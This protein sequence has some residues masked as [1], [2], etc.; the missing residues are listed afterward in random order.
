M[1]W[2]CRLLWVYSKV[3]F[4]IL[5][6]KIHKHDISLH[7][8]VSSLISFICILKFS[9]YRSF[10]SLGRFIPKYF[11]LF[12]VMVSGIVSLISLSDVSLLMNRNARDFWVLILY[13]ATLPNSLMSS[14]SLLLA[15][16]GLFMY[17]IRSSAKVR[18]L[19][20]LFQPGFLLFFFSDCCCYKF[21]NYVG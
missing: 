9:E 17:S 5:I 2:I 15:S 4:T 16:L 6:F 19:L 14:S 21:H 11:I 18:V 8:F 1:H 10:S 3:L 7:L 12:D 13:P 20:L